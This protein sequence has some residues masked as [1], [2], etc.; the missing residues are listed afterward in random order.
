MKY[1]NLFLFAILVL[2][3]CKND[4][5]SVKQITSK[6]MVTLENNYRNRSKVKD[7]FRISIPIEFEIIINSSKVK[8]I[9]WNFLVDNKILDKDYYDYDVYLKGNKIN[10][11]YQFTPD[12]LSTNKHIAIIIKENNYL[13]SKAQVL[14]LLSKYK[15][16]SLLDDL[17][18]GK[19]IELTTFDKF[20]ID[21][22]N[23]IN[24]F[25]KVNDSIIFKVTRGEKYFF[26]LDK[27]I[28]W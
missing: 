7:S 5:I 12:F 26:Y 10:P 13:I 20:R 6:E 17:K 21:N 14:E 3:S 16:K 15:T 23:L 25:R 27:K 22:K 11:I 1:L 8:Y 18:F 28:D 19:V 2:S 24:E 4:P 9:T